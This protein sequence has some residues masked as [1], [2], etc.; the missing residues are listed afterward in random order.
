MKL[1]LPT[2]AMTA[3]QSLNMLFL[4]VRWLSFHLRKI[5]KLGENTIE[6]YIKKG[7]KSN[8][9]L[10]FLSII[11]GCSQGLI[12]WHHDSKPFCIL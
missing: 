5:E 7:I 8:A 3:T 9:C 12:S 10:V 1:F 4:K 11:E 2:K 6:I